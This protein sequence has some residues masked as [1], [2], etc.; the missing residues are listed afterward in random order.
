MP[1]L[2]LYTTTTSTTTTTIK[3]ANFIAAAFAECSHAYKGLLTAA[4][5]IIEVAVVVVLA[6]SLRV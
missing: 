4:A 1:V 6:F 2:G 5:V 3:G